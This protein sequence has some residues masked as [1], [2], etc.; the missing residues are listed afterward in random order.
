MFVTLYYITEIMGFLIRPGLHR[1]SFRMTGCK[2][3]TGGRWAVRFTHRPPSLIPSKCPVIPTKGRNP[4]D[5]IR[6]LLIFYMSF[7]IIF[8]FD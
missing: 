6:T 2:D 8:D 5:F 1:D 7:Q 4:L 3:G